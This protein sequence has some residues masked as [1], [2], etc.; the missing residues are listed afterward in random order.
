M[1]S[2]QTEGRGF[3]LGQRKDQLG[4][5]LLMLLTSIRLAQDYE[6]DFRFNWFPPGADAPTLANPGDLFSERFMDRHFIDTAGYADIQENVEPIWK[7]LRDKAPDK[8]IAHL[9]AGGHVLLEEGFG[10]IAFPWEDADAIRARFPSLMGEI[11]FQS[12]MALRMTQIDA[13]LSAGSGTSVAYHIRRGDILNADPWMHKQWPSKIEPDELYSG[14]LTKEK[15]DVALVFSD[16]AESIDR[17]KAAHPEVTGVRSI[18]G[19][20]DY[21]V[22]QRDFLELYAMSRTDTIVAPAISAFSQAAAMISGRERQCFIHVLDHDERAA[23]YDVLLERLQSGTDN[24]VTPSEA[25]HLYAKLTT[26]L[27]THDREREAWDVGRIVKD[28]GAPNAF[29]PLLHAINCV[30]LKKWDEALDNIDSALNDPHL[31]KEAHTAALAI[32]SLIL[33]ALGRAQKCQ[34]SFLRAFWTK[35]FLPDVAIVGSLMVNRNRLRPHRPLPFSLPVVQSMRIPYVRANNYLEQNKLI[36]RRAYDFSTL[37]VEWPY[38]VMDGKA[39]RIV[40][41]DKALGDIHDA[42]M[43]SGT[44][45]NKIDRESYAALVQARM[46]D[47]DGALERH[48][49]VFQERS[50]DPLFIKREAEISALA[51]RPDAAAD[52]IRPLSHAKAAHPFWHYLYGKFLLQAG[53]RPGALA[54]WKMAAEGDQTTAMIHAQFADLCREMDDLETAV[55][56]LDRAHEIAPTQQKF[57]NRKARLAKL[58]EQV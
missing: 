28:G 41:N 55:L 1:A 9:E 21:S 43:G 48:H 56:A 34:H 27:A 23:A 35:P 14:H 33:G 6:T 42:V 44:D 4:A 57:L 38:F 17:F 20:G 10:I 31:W 15:P 3:F 19:D 26:H 24:F 53:D 49:R 11:E 25:A 18:L 5:R 45:D 32:Q 37:V 12:D 22:A 8:L 54:A 36:K 2:S 52:I 7:F 30:Y 13:A 40:A 39:D 58:A 29:V 16:Q 50:D 47:A 46:G 51:G